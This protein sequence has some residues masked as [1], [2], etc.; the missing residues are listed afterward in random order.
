M[1]AVASLLMLVIGAA[2]SSCASAQSSSLSPAQ[3]FESRYTLLGDCPV[4][5]EGA[6]GYDWVLLK[7]EGY[8]GM[9]IWW[10]YADSARLYVGFGTRMN[11]SG[12]FGFYRDPQ[13]PLEWRGRDNG[14][15]FVPHAVIIRMS[16]TEF[17]DDASVPDHSLAVFM[18]RDDGTSCLVARNLQDND[19]ARAA[20]DAS[21]SDGECLAEPYLYD[22]LL[23]TSLEAYNSPSE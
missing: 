2:T 15:G 23:E 22:G 13:W 4:V 14:E 7:C 18:L 21:A 17:D 10:R 1:R 11:D 3:A 12:W 20:A 9:P 5:A 16:R 8:G 6:P 19:N